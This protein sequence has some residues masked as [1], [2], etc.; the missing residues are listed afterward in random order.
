MALPNIDDRFFLFNVLKNLW[1]RMMQKKFVFVQ[2][3]KASMSAPHCSFSAD[4]GGSKVIQ[5]GCSSHKSKIGFWLKLNFD[6]LQYG[7]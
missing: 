6:N 4:T 7:G 1:K 5:K 2:F 3:G